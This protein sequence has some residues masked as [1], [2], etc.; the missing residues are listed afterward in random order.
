MNHNP[1][2]TAPSRRRE[3][4]SPAARRASQLPP[5]AR[6]C[7]RPG[8]RSPLPEHPSLLSTQRGSLPIRRDK[9]LRLDAR[10]RRF[11]TKGTCASD[12]RRA[13]RDL[14]MRHG[15]GESND[16]RD[17]HLLHL[18]ADRREERSIPDQIEGE[19]DTSFLQRTSCRDQVGWSPFFSTMYATLTKRCGPSVTWCLA[20]VGICTPMCRTV[21]ANEVIASTFRAPSRSIDRRRPPR[22][23]FP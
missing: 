16:V 4:R 21:G 11:W 8:F 3:R 2:P 20:G 22:T 12:R 6:G 14:I 5:S 1:G 23:P 9:T 19:L 15:A 18:R 17:P 7:R 10:P 13:P